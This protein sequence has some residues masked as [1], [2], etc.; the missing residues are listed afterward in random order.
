MT[1]ELTFAQ[2]PKG[3]ELGV[4]QVDD[5]CG[6]RTLSTLTKGTMGATH[7]WSDKLDPWWRKRTHE[8]K[9]AQVSNS[10]MGM[11]EGEEEIL[12]VTYPYETVGPG[13][14]FLPLGKPH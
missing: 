12:Q 13:K 4:A 6:K 1:K 3:N 7:S 8:S 9:K 14:R 5:L 10:L 2:E 11:G